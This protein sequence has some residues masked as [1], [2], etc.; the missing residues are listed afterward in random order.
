MLPN[1]L[2][3]NFGTKTVPRESTYPK[4]VG[5]ILTINMDFANILSI[6]IEV[7]S[8]IFYFVVIFTAYW[9]RFMLVVICIYTVNPKGFSKISLFCGKHTQST[10][11]EL[12]S[13]KN[14]NN[15]DKI[16]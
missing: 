10:Q 11:I 16:Q 8:Y 5:V 13:L 4:L 1:K 7:G 2:D 9:G 3:L 6:G 12:F 14:E 15:K